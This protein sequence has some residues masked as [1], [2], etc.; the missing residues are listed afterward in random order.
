MRSRQGVTLIEIAI[1][2]AIVGLLA[3]VGAGL[4]TDTIPSWRTR[5]A[6]NEFFAQVNAARTMAI[7]DGTEYRIWFEA[8]EA[9]PST[10]TSAAGTYWVQKGDAATESTSWD[11]LPVELDGGNSIQGEGYVNI[12]ADEEDELPGVTIQAIDPSLFGPAHGG[13]PDA[14]HFGPS[15]MLLNDGG[16]F[17]CDIN[18]DGG[19]DGFICVRFVNKEKAQAGDSDVWVVSISRAGMARMFHGT[20]GE[21]HAVGSGS[22]TSSASSGVGYSP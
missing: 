14:I 18:G 17:G 11:T 13:S 8:T 3:A 6:A 22:T 1:V 9:D 7:S 19:G 21:G 16:D 10:S 20:T 2:V 5:R 4:L 12:A 15:G